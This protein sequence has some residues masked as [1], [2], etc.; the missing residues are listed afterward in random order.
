MQVNDKGSRIKLL[1]RGNTDIKGAIPKSTEVPIAHILKTIQDKMPFDYDHLI[2]L[3]KIFD[4][5]LDTPPKKKNFSNEHA[6]FLFC[7]RHT[8]VFTLKS[9]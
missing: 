8:F 5:K 4:I 2:I 3:R 1:L 7:F 6:I 9:A